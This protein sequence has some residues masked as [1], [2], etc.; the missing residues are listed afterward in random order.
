[1]NTADLFKTLSDEN[2]LRILQL[3]LKNELCVCELESILNL[4]QSNL[5][6]VASQ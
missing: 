3:L 4:K 1:M 6:S 5:S 2:R